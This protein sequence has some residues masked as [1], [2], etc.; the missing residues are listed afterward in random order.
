MCHTRNTVIVP[1]N[2]KRRRFKRPESEWLSLPQ[3]E[4]AIVDAPT[5]E[6]A[7]ADLAAA[8]LVAPFGG[9]VLD[10]KA[11]PGDRVNADA[12]IIELADLT[13]LEVRVTVGQEDITAVHSGQEV[14][15]IFDVLPEETFQ[16]RVDRVIP[17][18]TAGQVVTYEVFIALDET[19]SGLLP[20]MTADAEIAIA[21][22]KDVLV[23][24]RRAIRARPYTT[25]S[26]PVLEAS[27]VVTRSVEIGLVG[28]LNAEI[29]SGLQEGDRVVM[30]R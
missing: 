18:K 11:R 6:K 8:T 10:V 23:L 14:R 30:E 15:L 25:V 27:R 7:Q 26:V 29:L 21:E 5:W 20:G 12:P 3:P 16:G 9:T 1:T 17:R 13:R 19:P 24:P 28:D 2:T 4:L 22:R